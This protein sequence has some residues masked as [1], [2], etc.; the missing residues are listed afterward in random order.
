MHTPIID[1]QIRRKR[2]RL[3]TSA[4]L[5][6][7]GIA[8]LM[9]GI[10][11]DDEPPLVAAVTAT[12][13]V[14]ASLPA[15]TFTP[16]PL[17]PTETPGPSPAK[18]ASAAAISP[19]STPSPTA[20]PATPSPTA[21]MER[22]LLVTPAAVTV[23]TGLTVSMTQ[24]YTGLGG[25]GATGSPTLTDTLPLT[26]SVVSSPTAT[27]K[28]IIESAQNSTTELTPTG[29]I[30]NSAIGAFLPTTGQNGEAAGQ[31]PGR[32]AYFVLGIVLILL[33]GG[34]LAAPEDR[35]IPPGR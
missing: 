13:P 5:F 18:T 29:V 4:L 1:Y 23:T 3:I 34:V 19:T 25:G 20:K 30:S 15:A 8:S 32:P 12:A 27:A 9:A 7:M 22:E 17:P 14:T 35:L 24:P 6:F 31:S 28:N 2:R 10:L 11:I 21:V 33:A 26:G 16:A